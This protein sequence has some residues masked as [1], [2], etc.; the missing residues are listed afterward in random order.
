MRLTPSCP[1]LLCGTCLMSQTGAMHAHV[2]LWHIDL[3]CW[4]GPCRVVDSCQDLCIEYIYVHACAG[5][6]LLLPSVMTN[7]S[8]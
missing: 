7:Q 3:H 2:M 1:L 4:V 5:T 6:I 8:R